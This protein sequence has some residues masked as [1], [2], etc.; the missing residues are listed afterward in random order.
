MSRRITFAALAAST[1]LIVSGTLITTHAVADREC[2]EESCRAQEA[3]EAQAAQQPVPPQAQAQAIE[4]SVAPASATNVSTIPDTVAAD[5]VAA[6]AK[7]RAKARREPV[8]AAKPEP[9][10]PAPMVVAKPEPKVEP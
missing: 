3:V 6:A 2:F 7:A 10:T 9:V 1:A 4:E 8:T 5:R